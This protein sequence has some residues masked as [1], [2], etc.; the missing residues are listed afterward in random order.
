[1]RGMWQGTTIW[2]QRQ[3]LYEAD[4]ATVQ[5]EHTE[6]YLL[7]K[8]PESTQKHLHTLPE[9]LRQICLK[10]PEFHNNSLSEHH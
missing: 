7:R 5:A 9:N 10:H 3:L 6:G 1:M 8:R 4:E 2:T